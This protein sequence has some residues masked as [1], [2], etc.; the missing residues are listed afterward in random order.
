MEFGAVPTHAYDLI[1]VRPERD[2]ITLSV[3]VD[4]DMTGEVACGTQPSARTLRTLARQFKPAKFLGN[5]GHVRVTVDYLKS[6]PGIPVA[7]RYAI[8]PD[9]VNTP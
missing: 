8:G 6:S 4:Q 3:L 7:H 9:G 5:S 1:L 2:S